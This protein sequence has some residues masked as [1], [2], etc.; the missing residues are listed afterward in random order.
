MIT[1]NA[2]SKELADMLTLPKRTLDQVIKRLKRRGIIV[3]EPLPGKT[4]VR[5]VRHDIK[6]VG[7]NP[8]QRKALKHTGKSGKKGAEAED[9][10]MA[11]Q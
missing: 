11:Y 10:S 3:L 5:L 1:I 9:V 2:S 7:I 4:Y 8:S 6:F